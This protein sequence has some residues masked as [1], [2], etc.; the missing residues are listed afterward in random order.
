VTQNVGTDGGGIYSSGAMTISDSVIS[1]NTASKNTFGKGGGIY[2]QPA[3]ALSVTLDRVTVS[4]NT[5]SQ[6]GGGIYNQGASGSLFNLQNVTLNG[7]SSAYGG[8]IGNFG[9]GSLSLL[10]TTVAD[11]TIIGPGSPAGIFSLANISFK[12]TLISANTPDNCNNSGGTWTSLGNNLDSG[13][14]CNFN[15]ASDLESTDPLLVSLSDNGG[16]TPTNAL[17]GATLVDPL[18]PAIDAGSDSGVPT[19]DQRGLPRTFGSHTDI[20]AYEY[21]L[22]TISGN[23]GIANAVLSYTDNTSKTSTA[24]GSGDYAF[25]VNSYWSG[26]VTPS[27]TGYKFTPNHKDYTN[28]WSNQTGQSYTYSNPVPVLSSIS[29]TNKWSG[30]PGLTLILFGTKF[31]PA[32]VVR[33]NGSPRVTTF[34]NTGKLTAAI[35]TA[36]LATA[37][38][39]TVTVF[40]PTPGGGTSVTKNFTVK[41]DVPVITGLSPASKIHGKPGFTLTVYGKKFSTGAKVRW[42]GSDRPTTFVNMYLLTA[43]ISA[44]DIATAGTANVRVF[45][46]TPGGGLSNAMTFTIQ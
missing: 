2:F 43:A 11:N 44:T 36:D 28:V 14:T 9:S 19:T 13:T 23:A 38:I 26:A 24:N 41:N 25:T 46:P 45:N 5:S 17:L 27:L 18:S 22:F 31:T 6:Y 3:T 29:P 34:V 8:A 20:G 42:N 7:N 32:S 37:S 15:E 40:N 35:T 12:N 39:A 30:R 16:I 1:D 10:N 4:G 21:T 33:W